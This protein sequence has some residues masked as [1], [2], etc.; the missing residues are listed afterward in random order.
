MY[1]S[2]SYQN[3]FFMARDGGEMGA[4]YARANRTP[5][6]SLARATRT[7][8]ESLDVAEIL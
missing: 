4:P 6:E 3:T 8:P 2:Y 7:P 1:I 5:P